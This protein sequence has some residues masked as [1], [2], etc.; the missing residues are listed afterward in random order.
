MKRLIFQISFLLLSVLVKGQIYDTIPHWEGGL[1]IIAK[2]ED[3]RIDSMM[4]ERG[5]ILF[6]ANYKIIDSLGVIIKES[7]FDELVGG[8]TMEIKKKDGKLYVSQYILKNST[9]TKEYYESGNLKFEQNNYF[10]ENFGFTETRTY[11]D[12]KFNSIEK[13]IIERRVIPEKFE[14][15]KIEKWQ[16]DEKYRMETLVVEQEVKD[17]IYVPIREIRFH[18][19]GKIKE[20][21]EYS[22]RRFFEFRNKEFYRKWLNDGEGYIGNYAV[23]LNQ[24]V[25]IKNGKW[26]YFDEAGN[27]I[28]EEIY[29]NGKLI[30]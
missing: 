28:K 27:L 12:N 7:K 25:K 19:N 17:S 29:N 4:K 9:L 2:T 18:P 3:E 15:I 5:G 22:K 16:I 26:K 11:Y 8:Q 20:K 13:I 21:G 23:I 6:R 1:M 30:E 10:D 14:E 24:R